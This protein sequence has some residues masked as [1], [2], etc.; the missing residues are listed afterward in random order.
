MM[1]NL[2]TRSQFIQDRAL[3]DEPIFNKF[4]ERDVVESVR[5]WNPKPFV[6]EAILQVSD[7]AFSLSDLQVQ[8]KHQG[9]GLLPWLKSIYRQ[10]ERE[11]AGFL[12]P[13]HIWQVFCS[14]FFLNAFFNYIGVLKWI[15]IN[16]ECLNEF[17]FSTPVD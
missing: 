3:L 16:M 13:I 9:K 8:K 15:L 6:E 17:N 4:W 10:A 14:F 5:Q 2:L 12:S 7:W 1:M 11:R